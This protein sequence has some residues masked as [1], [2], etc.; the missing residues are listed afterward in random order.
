MKNSLIKFESQKPV[1]KG[2]GIMKWTAV[3]A[4]SFFVSYMGWQFYEQIVIQP[5]REAM[6]DVGAKLEETR[7]KIETCLANCPSEATRSCNEEARKKRR[8][9]GKLTSPD[10]GKICK[11]KYLPTCETSCRND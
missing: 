3:G 9:L 1:L 5:E 2:S 10:E 11:E 6:L 7:K 8:T 4:V